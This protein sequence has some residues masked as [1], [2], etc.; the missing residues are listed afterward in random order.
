MPA[1]GKQHSKRVGA[2]YKEKVDI[3]SSTKANKQKVERGRGVYIERPTEP[4][5]LA[6]HLLFHFN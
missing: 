2:E 3:C 6:V 4:I 5:E 1:A